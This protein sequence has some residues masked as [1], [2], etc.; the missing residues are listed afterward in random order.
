MHMYLH[1]G[2]ILNVCVSMFTCGVNEVAHTPL[3]PITG[4]SCGVPAT[5]S[6]IMVVKG[7]EVTSYVLP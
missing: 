6:M 7:D 5:P 4:E 1:I 2:I 3:G